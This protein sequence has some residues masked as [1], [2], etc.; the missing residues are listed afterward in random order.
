MQMVW[1]I[2]LAL[3]MAPKLLR[4]VKSHGFYRRNYASN[5]ICEHCS[6]H[7]KVSTLSWRNFGDRAP[8]RATR[9]THELYL[10][11]PV[12]SLSCWVRHPGSPKQYY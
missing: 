7:A 9:F 10:M 1:E 5:S 8:W 4:E 12:E 3:T 2:Q 6:A 11:R